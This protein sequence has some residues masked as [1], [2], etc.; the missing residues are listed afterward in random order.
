MGAGA[1]AG[2]A[3]FESVEAALA[4]GK[5]QE[6]VDSWISAN[7]AESEAVPAESEAAATPAESEAAATPAESEAAA[8]PA[9]SEAAAPAESEGE[10]KAPEKAAEPADVSADGVDRSEIERNKNGEEEPSSADPELWN[11]DNCE[12][13]I[14]VKY[15][16]GGQMW[17]VQSRMRENTAKRPALPIPGFPMNKKAT[18]AKRYYATDEDGEFNKDSTNFCNG[19]GWKDIQT[20][21]PPV[22]VKA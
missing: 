10:T 5:T 14:L 15:K 7:P 2:A 12:V 1:S 13:D 11:V 19:Q 17:Y 8:T 21:N 3:P 16:M 22:E 4:G 9:E 18:D 6:E 20:A